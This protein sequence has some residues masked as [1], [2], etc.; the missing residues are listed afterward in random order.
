MI[1]TIYHRTNPSINQSINRSIN[2]SIVWSFNII[3]KQS[4]N[5]YTYEIIN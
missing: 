5:K 1:W 4:T 2:Q 3:N